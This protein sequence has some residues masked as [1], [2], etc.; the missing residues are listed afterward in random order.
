[1]PRRDP[2]SG[3]G[4]SQDLTPR[5]RPRPRAPIWR[6][7]LLSR[8]GLLLPRRDRRA[9]FFHLSFQEFLAAGRIAHISDDR[10][11]FE[12]VF[13][14]R[15]PVPGW[16]PTLLF[17]FAAGI[18]SRRPQWGLDLLA[19]LAADLERGRFGF[20]CV[21]TAPRQPRISTR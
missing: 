6:E 21:L 8:S 13:R 19:Q 14:A 16:H 11:T 17:L 18:S 7:E 1:M 15:A 5:P 4:T 3:R 9:A 20:R 2:P 12:R 10:A